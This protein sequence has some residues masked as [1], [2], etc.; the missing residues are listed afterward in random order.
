LR[1]VR[2]AY[3]LPLDDPHQE[4]PL[5]HLRTT[6][7]EP[8]QLTDESG[9]LLEEKRRSY[10]YRDAHLDAIFWHNGRRYQ[11]IAFDD[12]HRRIVAQPIPAGDLRTQGLEDVALTV[13]R[14]LEPSRQLAPDIAVGFGGGTLVSRVERYALYQAVRVMRC[15]NRDCRHETTNLDL[16]RCPR[17]GS[18]MR[19]RQVE[20]VIEYRPVPQP[21]E[22][23]IELETQAG[24]LTFAP[25]V[26]NRF[27]E[28][29]W[30]R[31]ERPGNGSGGPSV[32]RPVEP[33]FPHALHTFKH[34]LLKAMPEQIRCDEGDIGG[35]TAMTGAQAQFYIYDAF[36]GGL[37]F[38]EQL[39]SEPEALFE[40]ALARLEGCTCTDDEGCLVCLK[41]FRCRQFN[42]TLSKLAGRYLLRLALGRPVAPLLSDLANYAQT[43]V[44]RA[45]IVVR[46]SG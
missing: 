9:Q 42:D 1:V 16:H 32:S 20:K 23:K 46:P 40:A 25:S 17:C 5:D 39:Y 37:G 27:A 28:E 34:A 44:P 15:R 8:Y 41:Y 29:F 7:G 12:A 14:E 30:P 24:W 3:H 22:L 31:W 38:A 45:L 2:G 6:E 26:L 43:A 13:R 36:P 21:P 10:A 19:P 11:V 33:D 18:P 4:P 35:L